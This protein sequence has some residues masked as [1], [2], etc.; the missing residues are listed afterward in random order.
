MRL[1]LWGV[2][3]RLANWAL[4]TRWGQAVIE[5]WMEAESVK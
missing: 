2:A 5:W 4:E 1:W 3:D